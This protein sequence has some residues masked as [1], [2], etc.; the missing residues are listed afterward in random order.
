M[1]VI[2]TQKAISVWPMNEIEN[3][4]IGLLHAFVVV[5]G[6][7]VLVVDSSTNRS[8]L[9]QSS[10]PPPFHHRCTDD[11]QHACDYARRRPTMRA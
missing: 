6:V 9:P 5:A 10:L 8:S 2:D 11:C 7:A 4:N 1:H 3:V